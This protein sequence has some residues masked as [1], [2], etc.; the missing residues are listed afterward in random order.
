VLQHWSCSRCYCCVRPDSPAVIACICT[1]IGVSRN[2]V[3]WRDIA[4]QTG[5]AGLEC[6]PAARRTRLNIACGDKAGGIVRG[7][8]YLLNA[9]APGHTATRD[10]PRIATSTWPLSWRSLTQNGVLE[11]FLECQRRRICRVGQPSDRCFGDTT[12]PPFTCSTPHETKRNPP[13]H[14]NKVVAAALH[15]SWHAVEASTCAAGK[16]G[17]ASRWRFVRGGQNR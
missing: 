14:S 11:W 3:I 1:P 9:A 15:S 2:R 5:R 7:I 6:C 8:C 17:A 13:G 16:V 4:R 10:A 12:S